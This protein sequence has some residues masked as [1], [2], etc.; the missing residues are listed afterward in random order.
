MLLPFQAS[1]ETKITGYKTRVWLTKEKEKRYM[2]MSTHV[3]VHVHMTDLEYTSSFKEYSTQLFTAN[4]AMKLNTHNP[5]PLGI[6]LI[7]ISPI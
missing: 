5:D 7:K 4:S 2:C 3:H 6:T 1:N